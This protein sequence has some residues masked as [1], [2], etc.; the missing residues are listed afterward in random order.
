MESKLGKEEDGARVEVNAPRHIQMQN[1]GE[2]LVL[3]KSLFES[4]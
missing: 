2:D 4:Q 1:F 3:H